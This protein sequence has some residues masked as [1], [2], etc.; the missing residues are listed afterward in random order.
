[1][2]TIAE[3]QAA[4]AAEAAADE[5][6]Q[7][8]L[9]ERQQETRQLLVQTLA[10][11]AAAALAAATAAVTRPKGTEDV[12]EIDTSG[13]IDL[14]WETGG[15]MREHV[16]VGVVCGAE[17]WVLWLQGLVHGRVNAQQMQH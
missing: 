6:K 5:E 12:E 14:R 16:G 4:E 8:R 3:R 17:M 9:T 10:A 7:K 1:M 11:D 2:Q 13:E 15:N